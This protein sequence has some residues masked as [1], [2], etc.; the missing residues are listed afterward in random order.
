MTD[1]SEVQLPPPPKE[2]GRSREAR[3]RRRLAAEQ[4]APVQVRSDTPSPRTEEIRT[5]PTR[6]EAT[7]R[8]RRRRDNV[9]RTRDLKLGI[10]FNIDPAYEYRWVNS[11]VDDQRIHRLTK[12]DDWERVNAE[13]EASDD[14]GAYIRR[15]VGEGPS[16][17]K[18][19]YLCRKPKD[20]YEADHRKGQERNDKLMRHIRA[21]QN[22]MDISRSLKSSDNVYGADG[23]RISEHGQD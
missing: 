9:D 6:A 15:A 19:A 16:G 12:D 14:T 21:G 11:G 4:A 22:P 13:G 2:D 3:E 7:Q 17:P 10:S 20:W 18:Y 5:R 23:I 1:A 8:E